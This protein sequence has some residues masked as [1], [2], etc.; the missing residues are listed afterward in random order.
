MPDDT[1]TAARP[2]AGPDGA[3]YRGVIPSL[4]MGGKATE[5]AGFYARA[6]GARD[7]GRMADEDNPGKLLHCMLEINGGGL[8]MSDCVAPWETASPKPQGVTMQLVVADGDVWWNRAVEAGCRVVMP[9]QKMFW[10]DRW[11]MLEDPFGISW[12]IDE[13]TG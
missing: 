7:L 2:D 9:F 1:L 11:G 4:S 13:P 8:M 6:F 10:G 5:A 3:A 12:A